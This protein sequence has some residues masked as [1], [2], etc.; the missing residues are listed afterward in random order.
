MK[1]VSPS[2]NVGIWVNQTENEKK[3]RLLHRK[4]NLALDHFLKQ[5]VEFH[6]WLPFISKIQEEL[7]DT[8]PMILWPGDMDFFRRLKSNLIRQTP[9]LTR[10]EVALHAHI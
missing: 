3:A 4:L 6:G 10:N 1:Q 7:A 5:S 9:V 2:L 8:H